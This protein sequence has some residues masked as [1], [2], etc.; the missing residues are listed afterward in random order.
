MRNFVHF[1][2]AALVI[3][4]S[5]GCGARPCNCP[6]V[7]S[8]HWRSAAH[9]DVMYIPESEY[10]Y[11]R[12]PVMVCSPKIVDVTS[13]RLEVDYHRSGEH[14]AHGWIDSVT[15]VRYECPLDRACLRELHA[16]PQPGQDDSH[17]EDRRHCC[18]LQ[19]G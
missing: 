11:T 2:S 8:S 10:G 12:Q 9:D 19:P 3:V 16:N 13:M 17:C 7:P 5:N 4:G 14:P 6:T 15:R 18:V 1:I